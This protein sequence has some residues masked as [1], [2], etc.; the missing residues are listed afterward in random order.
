MPD[1]MDQVQDFNEAH[2]SDALHRHASQPRKLGRTSCANLDCGDAIAPPRTALGAQLC[3][4]CQQE[5]EA[6]A[7]HLAAWR[8]R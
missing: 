7:V 5:E 6:Q 8:R 4:P 3:L 2:T 1:A